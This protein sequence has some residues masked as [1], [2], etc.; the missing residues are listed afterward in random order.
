MRMLKTPFYDDYPNAEG[1]E[2]CMARADREI[3]K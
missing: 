3:G 1:C 2:D